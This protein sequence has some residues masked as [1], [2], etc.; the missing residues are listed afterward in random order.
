M[1]LWSAAF[2]LEL[3][4]DNSAADRFRTYVADA[5]YTLVNNTVSCLNIQGQD[6]M[7]NGGTCVPDLTNATDG[8]YEARCIQTTP[9]SQAKIANSTYQ[10]A[11]YMSLQAWF[12]NGNVNPKGFTGNTNTLLQ[13]TLTEYKYPNSNYLKVAKIGNNPQNLQPTMLRPSAL[14]TSYRIQLQI[15]AATN[16]DIQ[17]L[18]PGTDDPGPNYYAFEVFI[19]PMI[20]SPD[21]GNVS[22]NANT[23]YQIINYNPGSQCTW[24]SP[25]AGTAT[26]MAFGFSLIESSP[27]IGPVFAV[28]ESY[29]WG[30]FPSDCNNPASYVYNNNNNK[31][32]IEVA[33]AFNTNYFNF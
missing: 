5:T 23:C 2:P 11:V 25:S 4:I 1:P 28:D 6:C 17:A 30:S 3:F 13:A 33:S 18:T 15:N 21:V 24:Y 7:S 14:N 26:V 19:C 9:T 22:V 16:G 20:V 29:I 8:V 27:E 31:T 12:L 32:F 10:F